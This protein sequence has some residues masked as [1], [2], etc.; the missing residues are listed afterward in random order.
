[1]EEIFKRLD[2]DSD[3][4]ITFEEYYAWYSSG[5]DFEDAAKDETVALFRPDPGVD[6]R[7]VFVTG[8][9]Q[10]AGEEVATR[11]FSR[12]GEVDQVTSQACSE[13]AARDSF[14]IK[15]ASIGELLS[16]Q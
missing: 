4:T 11:F 6:E 5:V 15:A 8:F 7:K 14:S 13:N 3:G 12:C 16:L 10:N 1:M 9:P 2:S